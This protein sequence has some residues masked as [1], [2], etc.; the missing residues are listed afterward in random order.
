VLVDVTRRPDLAR[1]Y[2]VASVP[3]AVR[4]DARG[5]VLERL[6]G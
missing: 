6:A 5:A 1:R 3:L 4:V 2:H